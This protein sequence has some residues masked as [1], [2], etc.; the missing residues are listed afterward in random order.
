LTEVPVHSLVPV[1]THDHQQTGSRSNLLPGDSCV[2]DNFLDVASINVFQ[3][4]VVL[5]I[6]QSTQLVGSPYVSFASGVE[7]VQKSYIFFTGRRAFFI[8]HGSC[9]VRFMGAGWIIHIRSVERVVWLLSSSFMIDIDVS[10]P[11]KSFELCW[12]RHL[13]LSFAVMGFVWILLV[14]R[15]AVYS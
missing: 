12:I 15:V 11:V 4:N 10:F 9:F 14:G 5:L 6:N 7:A 8:D 13:P 3:E 2:V 1:L